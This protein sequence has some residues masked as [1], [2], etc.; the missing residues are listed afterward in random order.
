MKSDNVVIQKIQKL[1]A[2]AGN[3]P[4]ENER[5]VAMERV[6]ELL[7]KY[8][9][10]LLDVENAKFS[11]VT[12]IHAMHIKKE[13]W[14]H[15][16]LNAVCRLYYTRHLTAEVKRKEWPIF[17]GTSENIQATISVVTF[18]VETIKRQAR[19]RFSSSKD[20]RSFCVGATNAIIDRAKAIIERAEGAPTTGTQLMVLTDKLQAKNDEFI[21][22]LQNVI[23]RKGR[24]T[25]SNVNPYAYV[26]GLI[27]GRRLSL[28][29]QPKRIGGEHE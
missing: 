3:N 17:I 23:D 22:G 19:E 2:L 13:R 15:F 20:K 14:I 12:M 25:N 9:L 11:D 6:H 29:P 27:E 24:D 18:L 5:A 1:L 16:L 21:S 8:N 7:A 4:N 28:K 26:A 10:S